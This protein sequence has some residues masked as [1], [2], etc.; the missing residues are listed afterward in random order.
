MTNV[1]IVTDS[2]A[3][4][5]ASL[6]RGLPVFTVPLQVIWDGK[7]YSD[8]VDIHP[9][10]FYTRLQN[11]KSMPSTSQP[12]P[13]AFQTLFEKLLSEEYQ[14]LSINISSKLSGT[15]ASAHHA[16]TNLPGKPIELVDSR[17]ASM[18]LGFQVLVTARAAA[19]GASLQECKALAEQAR[20]HTGVFFLPATLDFLHR[21]GR[22]GGAATFF[23]TALNL[24]P[25][26]QLKNGKIEPVERV[27]TFSKA[28]NRLVELFADHVQK[29]APIR[30][31]GLH[32]NNEAEALSLLENAQKLFGLNEINEAFC[33]E[34]SPVIGTHAGP[35]TIGL[36]FMTGM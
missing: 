15:V 31:C 20:D 1:A 8:G 3:N 35:G 25:I 24:K 29:K 30:L 27:R 6:T 16:M 11:S 13:H 32:A 4:L 33:T 28:K 2:T 12:S 36:A 14:I 19:Q 26:L 21:G 18:A 22:L 10:E 23:G 7:T 17:A 9:D 5:P 34:V